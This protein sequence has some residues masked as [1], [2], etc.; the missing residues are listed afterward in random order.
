M[1]DCLE[2]DFVNWKTKKIGQPQLLSVLNSF[3]SLLSPQNI[4]WISKDIVASP[5]SCVRVLC[6]QFLEGCE[7][8]LPFNFT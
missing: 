7:T 4:Y 2:M 6:L 3:R 5:S 8:D 1:L